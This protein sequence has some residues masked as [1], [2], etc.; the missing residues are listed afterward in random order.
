ME[1]EFRQNN[2]T[3]M[4]SIFGK[5]A[6]TLHRILQDAPELNK[7][8]IKLNNVKTKVFKCIEQ[9]HLKMVLGKGK[10]MGFQFML[11][12]NDYIKII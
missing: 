9:Y 4:F 2:G 6:K 12:E 10:E 7:T 5:E 11:S 1:L 3:F 8:V